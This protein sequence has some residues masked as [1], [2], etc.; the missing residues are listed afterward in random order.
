ME[1][2]FDANLNGNWLA[3]FHGRLEAPGSYRF[4]GLF[5]QAQ[6]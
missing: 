5:I 2:D 3:I 4:D 6:S 1:L